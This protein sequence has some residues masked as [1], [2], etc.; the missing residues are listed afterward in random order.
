MK[1]DEA[2][3][4]LSDAPATAPGA[5]EKRQPAQA[6]SPKRTGQELPKQKPGTEKT[7]DRRTRGLASASRGKTPAKRSNGHPGVN[8]HDRAS[9]P[10]AAHTAPAEKGSAASVDAGGASAAMAVSSS[11]A[12]TDREACAEAAPA[13][14]GRERSRQARPGGQAEGEPRPRVPGDA[15]ARVV[16][17][18]GSASSGAQ[19]K[20]PPGPG[21]EPLPDDIADFVDEIHS[22]IDLFEI[23]HDL[24]ISKDEKIK[25]RAIE[26][27]LEMKYGR[28]AE[29]SEE[30]VQIIMN[31]P[32]PQR[33]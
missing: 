14:G 13:P 31:A 20:P 24:L 33:D 32:R 3:S 27:I 2:H 18:E 6:G 4:A 11:A 10:S 7:R 19:K 9:S 8:G 17:G 26:K 29:S 28:S 21:E 25:Q 16:A 5:P 30:P 1:L 12:G 23:L 15:N 22:R